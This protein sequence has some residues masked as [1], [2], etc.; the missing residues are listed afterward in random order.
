MAVFGDTLRQARA[1]KGVTLREA[2]QDLR[3]NRHYLAALE[4]ESFENLPPLTY[5]RGIVRS[6]A[7]YLGLDTGR[8]LTLFEE[9]RG[10][11]DD[12]PNVPRTTEPVDIPN[13]W[14]PNFA[15]IAFALIAGAVIMTW[16]YSAFFSESQ[17]EPSPV[18]LQPT[19]TPVSGDLIFV[20]SQTPL[21][22]T[23]TATFT[24]SPTPTETPEPSPTSP[25][26]ETPADAAATSTQSQTSTSAPSDRVSQS[27]PTDLA[28]GE[29]AIKITALADIWIQVAADGVLYFEGGLQQGESTDW[30]SGSSFTV[31]TNS[32]V[33][34]LFTNH[35]GQE[36]FMD[37]TPGEVVYQL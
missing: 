17:A 24:P 32:G 11:L 34:T 29:A 16:M 3:I 18:V 4:E 28:E 27:A 13:H 36:F 23:A 6:Y 21:I 9:S 14:T 30:V 15:I 12:D 33:N 8:V 22:P 20:P 37:D 25:S 26:T 35:L 1:Q 10:A 19:V 2:E 7:T 5:Q 31:Y